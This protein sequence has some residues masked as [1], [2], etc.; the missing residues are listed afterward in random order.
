M[1]KYA[2]FMVKIHDS[3]NEGEKYKYDKR[4]WVWL[5]DVFNYFIG[6]NKVI[7]RNKIEAGIELVPESKFRYKRKNGYK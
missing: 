6:I 5:V 3:C 1:L 7:Y 4:N 2:R